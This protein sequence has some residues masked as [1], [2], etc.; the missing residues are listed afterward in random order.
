MQGISLQVE[1]SGTI[2]LTADR[3][4]L[5]QLLVILLDNA[6]QY[7]S[8]GGAIRLISRKQVNTVVIE[9]RDTGCGI[10][11]DDL[12]HIFDRF[13]RGDK[14]RP[15]KNS[16]A[17]LGLA[18]AQWIVDKHNGKIGVESEVGKGTRVFV[19]LPAEKS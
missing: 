17:G 7:T 12:P 15:R 9:V 6:I 2:C 4:R 5:H 18:I 19:T 3:E 8:Q 16:G 1:Y 11:V 10:A 13:F 14:V